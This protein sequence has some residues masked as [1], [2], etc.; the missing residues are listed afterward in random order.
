MKKIWI[1]LLALSVLLVGC[2]GQN[3]KN[4][5]VV[6]KYA[7]WDSVQAPVYRELADEFEKNNPNIKVEFETTPYNQYWTKLQAAT[8]GGEMPDV[9]WMNGPNFLKYASYDMLLPLNEIIKKDS[10]DMN[11]Y[12]EGIKDLYQYKGNQYGIPKD[13]DSI[14]LWYNKALFDKAGLQYPTDQW[15]WDDMK[16]AAINIQANVKGVYGVAIPVY[17]NQ[18]SYYNI[19]PQNGGSIISSDR[20]E[21]GYGDEN[22]IKAIEMIKSIFDENASSDYTTML[23]NKAT[24]MFQSEQVAMVY[25]GSWRASPLNA[26]EKI[27][28][29]LGVVTMP[30]IKNNSTVVHGIGYAI[31]KNSKHPEAA[32]KF[33][34]F[35]SNKESNDYV[36]KSGVVIPAYTESQKLWTENYKNID[37]SAY[38]RALKNNVSYP[39]SFDT[40]KWSHVQDVYL[41]K[42]WAG[43]MS[44]RE[45]CKNIKEEMDSILKSEK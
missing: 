44:P 40:A 4:E 3:E 21:S 16:K 31:G 1:L 11:K 30:K 9:V 33:V 29:H 24:Q 26:D 13:V 41:T 19:I 37:V 10:I 36:A 35:L 14:A 20:K 5:K 34:K 45:A 22:T 8:T 18:S 32:W 7:L 43:T 28:G 2:G 25:Q 12:V 15:T 27:N 39:V 6:I 17:E 42:V 38:I 23:E